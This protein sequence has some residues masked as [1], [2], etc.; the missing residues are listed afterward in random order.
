[1]PRLRGLLL[2][3]V[4]WLKKWCR[5]G[6]VEFAE[7]GGP[8]FFPSFS[9]LVLSYLSYSPILCF[10][11]I[12]F[13][14]CA[15]SHSRVVAC[16]A[17]F[18]WLFRYIPRGGGRWGGKEVIQKKKRARKTLFPQKRTEHSV[19]RERETERPLLAQDPPP[20]TVL[21]LAYSL[22]LRARGAPGSRDLG[23]G[24]PF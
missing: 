11:P 7:I 10:S 21:H 5:K 13:F 23:S 1:M 9:S 15:C 18:A 20:F 24:T 14:I 19:E 17:Y 4:H 16:L 3:Q 8:F 12:N 2:T 6:R 22:H